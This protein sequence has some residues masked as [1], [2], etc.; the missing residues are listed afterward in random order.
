MDFDKPLVLPEDIPLIL[1]NYSIGNVIST[2]PLHGVPNTTV[3]VITEQRTVAVRVYGQG[4]SSI[5]HIDLE[6]KVLKHLDDLGFQSPRVIPG[7]DGMS[8]QRWRHYW[9]CVTDFIH[10]EVASSVKLTPELVED[11]GR[12]VASFQT[13]MRGF[14]LESIP[15]GETFLERGSHVLELLDDVVKKRGLRFASI[16]VRSAW[17]HA[18]RVLNEHWEDL[19]KNI[20]HADIWPTNVIVIANRVVGLID[21][22]DCLYGPTVLDV[23]I[24]L[25]E[26]SMFQDTTL[27]HDLA[28]AFLTGFF[29]SGGSITEI[30]E[31]L[32]LS[33]ME[34]TCAM[35]VAYYAMQSP[36]F[37][38][39]EVY[40][41]RLDL[42]ANSNYREKMV[43]DLHK[44]IT[45]TRCSIGFDPP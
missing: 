1:S 9:V 10:G 25:M 36:D 28:E 14:E 16:S 35:W 2:E 42:F 33:A 23:A 39:G 5:E 8:V 44:L 15:P 18:A 6:M 24:P 30:E 37:R 11:V 43:S 20:I 38:E 27:R 17:D 29:R 32:L 7:S 41:R 12:L 45:E 13:A 31:A 21:F 19:N 4:Q 40:L 26:F 22:D 3:K 34:M